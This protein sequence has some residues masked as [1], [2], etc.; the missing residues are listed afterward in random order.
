M[1]RLHLV[2]IVVLIQIC[3]QDVR[4]LTREGDGHGAP[5]A[6]V[7]PGDHCLFA[8]QFAGPFVAVFAMIGTRIHSTRGP[9]HRLLL[10][11]IGRLRM[12][13]GH[14]ELLFPQ[15]QRYCGRRVPRKWKWLKASAHAKFVAM[16]AVGGAPKRND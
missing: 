5:D 14:D 15:P 10:T 3:D 13:W 1:Q 8:R 2:R 9:W 12:S 16:A 11:R 6:A 7:A 4:A